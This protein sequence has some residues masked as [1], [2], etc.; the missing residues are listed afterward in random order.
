MRNIHLANHV[1][2]R[3]LTLHALS[4]AMRKDTFIK[5]NCHLQREAGSLEYMDVLYKL[6]DFSIHLQST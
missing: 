4:A 5:L 2:R 3:E 1:L 6:F